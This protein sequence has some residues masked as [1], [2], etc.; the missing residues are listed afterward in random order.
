MCVNLY[1]FIYM[2]THRQTGVPSQVDSYRRQKLALDAALLNTQYYKVG[3]KGKM[4]L[5]REWS[6]ALPNNLV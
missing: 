2:N 6:S 1:M 5:S 3:I 4:E